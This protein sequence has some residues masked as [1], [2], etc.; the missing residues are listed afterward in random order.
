MGRKLLR[1]LDSH[2]FSVD[3][4]GKNKKVLDI[5]ANRL[6]MKYSPTINRLITSF[7]TMTPEV[8]NSFLEFCLTQ[9]KKISELQKNEGQIGKA[10]LEEQKKEYLEIAKL[11]NE[12]IELQIKEEKTIKRVKL[13]DGYLEIPS[14]WI[15]L[16]ESDSDLYSYAGVIECRNSAHYNVPHF[17]FL[18]EHKY[19][20]DYTD[21]LYEKVH[22]MC[23]EVW[24]D[25]KEII[26]KQV[27]PVPDPTTPG[28]YLNLDEFMA[29]PT[30]G[31]FHLPLNTETKNP[32]CGAQIVHTK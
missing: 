8:K 2:R 10:F 25:F 15:V 26:K 23:I 32:V 29:A 27:K 20:C 31:H 9:C 19:A 3:I 5:L 21:D 11:I 6:N 18:N 17:V 24:P 7:C 28:N 16:N 14:E 4:G 22:K 13:K 12:G 1:E 30:I